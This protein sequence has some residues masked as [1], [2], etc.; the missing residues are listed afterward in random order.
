MRCFLD[1]L[2]V[3]VRNWN[4][5]LGR[6]RLSQ[7]REELNCEN[8]R[9]FE[10]GSY[11]VYRE[12]TRETPSTPENIKISHAPGVGVGELCATTAG[13]ARFKLSDILGPTEYDRSAGCDGLRVVNLAVDS[14]RW[15]Q[16]NN[17]L[18]GSKQ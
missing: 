6:V 13:L 16:Q 10:V 14:R 8:T 5:F 9:L 1:M 4:P 12:R 2:P 3:R 7:S 17:D 11:E 18:P 15:P